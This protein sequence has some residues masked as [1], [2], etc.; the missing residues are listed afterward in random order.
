M[1]GRKVCNARCITNAN[2][3][4]IT[5]KKS[6]KRKHTHEPDHVAADVRKVVNTVKR[7]ARESPNEPPLNKGMDV[8]GAVEDDDVLLMMPDRNFL[9]RIMNTTQNEQRPPVHA[10][11]EDVTIS[12]PYNATKNNQL[13]IFLDSEDT[14]PDNRF[15]IYTTQ[16][17]LRILSVSRLMYGDGTFKTVPQQF[18]QL[19]TIH[20]AF[21]DHV[22]PLV[23]VHMQKKTEAS[24]TSTLQKL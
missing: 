24:Y 10:S 23:Y 16:A 18:M 11:L 3:E 19:Y 20:G 4:E 12:P 7:R 22:F 6:G 5:I 9:R 1:R 13:L 21:Q 8:V 14:L 2:L 15:L 17:N